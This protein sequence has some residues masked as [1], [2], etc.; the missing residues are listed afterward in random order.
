MHRTR[1]VEL[2]VFAVRCLVEFVFEEVEALQGVGLLDVDRTQDAVPAPVL[3]DGA[4]GVVEVAR[5]PL[6]LV[7]EA[8]LAEEHPGTVQSR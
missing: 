7:H 6:L 4:L 1:L 2:E 3:V 8:V 5:H